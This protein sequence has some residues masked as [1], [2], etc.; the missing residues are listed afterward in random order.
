MI[1]INCDGKS[2]IINNNRILSELIYNIQNYIADK[3]ITDAEIK[4]RDFNVTIITFSGKD[5]NG[6]KSSIEFEVHRIG[7]LTVNPKLKDLIKLAHQCPNC[8]NYNTNQALF[9]KSLKV[10]RNGI[11]TTVAAGTIIAGIYGLGTLLDEAIEKEDQMRLEQEQDLYRNENGDDVRFL[12]SYSDKGRY[13]DSNHYVDE[14]GIKYVIT[15]EGKYIEMGKV[16][17]NDMTAEELEELEEYNK[18]LH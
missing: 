12:P 7:L 15:S 5:E 8:L 1:K 14:N 2:H 4:N 18:A 9:L 10:V 6:N 13:I 3:T 11:A 16:V 17:D